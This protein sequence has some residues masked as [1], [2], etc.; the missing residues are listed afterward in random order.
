MK[1][2]QMK[3]KREEKRREWNQNQNIVLKVFSIDIVVVFRTIIIIIIILRRWL[4]DSFRCCCCYC[5][6]CRD[7]FMLVIA[8]VSSRWK[9]NLRNKQL[10]RLIRNFLFFSKLTIL[11]N[12]SEKKDERMKKWQWTRERK[13]EK[14]Y[15]FVRI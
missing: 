6:Y 2:I 15:P 7:I 1:W 5:Y 10:E 3:W 4:M 9:M 14:N 12:Q 11:T 13:K 8:T